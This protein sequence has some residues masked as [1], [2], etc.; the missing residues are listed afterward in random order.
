MPD[1]VLR[2]ELEGEEVL[3]NPATGMYHLLNASGRR[4]VLELDQGS[5]LEQAIESVAAA[6]GANID[7]VRSDCSAFLNDMLERGLLEEAT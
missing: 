2:A 3:L 6:S 7:Q 5:S 4:L 1:G